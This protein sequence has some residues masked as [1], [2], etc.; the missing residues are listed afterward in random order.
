MMDRIEPKNVAK[1][2]RKDLKKYFPM[3]K[4]SVKTE[5]YSMGSSINVFWTNGPCEKDVE[6]IVGKYHGA[7]F[8]STEDIKRG[9]GQPYGNDFINFSRTVTED[10]YIEVAETV[11]RFYKIETLGK[12][13]VD[14]LDSYHENI[15]KMLD[16]T[17]R[18]YCWRI[19]SRQSF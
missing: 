8:D 6:T 16:C 12:S 7:T 3:C 11:L 1:L 15:V 10:K 4:F 14:L 18:V 5:L 19:I 17:L 9:N 13:A 2:V